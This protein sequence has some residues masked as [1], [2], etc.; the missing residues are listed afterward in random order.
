MSSTWLSYLSVKFPKRCH[1]VQT[2]MNHFIAAFKQTWLR[3]KKC[4]TTAEM[5]ISI[6][7][8][9]FNASLLRARFAPAQDIR[10]ADGQRG[11][12]PQR[13]RR[14]RLN[15]FDVLIETTGDLFRKLATDG[16]DALCLD[17]KR[18]F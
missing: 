8:R 17:W 10:V 1:L 18:V 3:G 6:T 15:H 14:R 9:Q 4:Y 7:V 13:K 2:L 11:A 16:V 5:E 12:L